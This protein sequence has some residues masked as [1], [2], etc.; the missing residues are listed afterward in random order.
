MWSEKMPARQVWFALLTK[1]LGLAIA[2]VVWLVALTSMLGG[3]FNLGLADVLPLPWAMAVKAYDGIGW[4]NTLPGYTVYV[5][6]DTLLAGLQIHQIWVFVRNQFFPRRVAAAPAATSTVVGQVAWSAIQ[7]PPWATAAILSA[8]V[9]VTVVLGA[10]VITAQGMRGRVTL[11]DALVGLGWGPWVVAGVLC[12]LGLVGSFSHVGSAKANLGA[13]FGATELTADHALT[14]RVH[15]FASRMQLPAPAVAYMNEVN[16]YAA[17]STVNDAVVVLGLPLI[18]NL[19]LPEL[20]AVI[21]HELGHIISGDMRRMET[22]DGYQT[23]VGWAVAAPFK[24]GGLMKHAGGQYGGLGFLLDALGNL[25]RMVFLLASELF[26]RG[27]SRHREFKADAIAAALV[28]PEAMASALRKLET[29]T[30]KPS[31]A[32]SKFAYMMFRPPS[33]SNF[34]GAAFATHPT[35]ADRV[36]ALENRTHLN[37]LPRVGGAQ[38]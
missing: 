32:E 16:A 14:K 10:A 21:C 26:V 27:L 38:S 12:V 28:S 35:I 7:R 23:A 25:F 20:D 15:A 18:R 8:C 34:L 9:I 30:A 11:V 1:V 4:L 37:K 31:D 2:R 29:I 22:A 19:S 13:A 3:T 6:G 24:L 5:V 36:Q 17:G 33:V